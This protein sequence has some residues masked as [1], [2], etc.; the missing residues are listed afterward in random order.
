MSV[1][2]RTDGSEI[3]LRSVAFE[4]ITVVIQNGAKDTN[5]S[6]LK[7]V[8]PFLEKLQETFSMQVVSNDDRERQVPFSS[9]EKICFWC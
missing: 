2:Y 5:E 8:P 3:G 7:T 6:L 4:A 9:F 1:A